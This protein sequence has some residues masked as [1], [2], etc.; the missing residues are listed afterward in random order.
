MNALFSCNDIAQWQL[1]CFNT[2]KIQQSYSLCTVGCA[3]PTLLPKRLFCAGL[4]VCQ[5]LLGGVHMVVDALKDIGLVVQLRIH[6]LHQC[7]LNHSNLRGTKTIGVMHGITDSKVQALCWTAQERCIRALGLPVPCASCPREHHQ[8]HP[9][10]SPVS[11]SLVGSLACQALRS[12]VG[13]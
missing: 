4:H 5:S 13:L 7:S 11:G 6:A 10:S 3:R 12:R 1:L 9:E 2:C 8:W